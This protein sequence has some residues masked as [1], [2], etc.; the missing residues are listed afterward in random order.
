MNLTMLINRILFLVCFLL[1]ALSFASGI[2]YKAQHN[3]M[4]F[5]FKAY[6]SMGEKSIFTSY[7]NLHEALTYEQP[8]TNQCMVL[9]EQTG[10]LIAEFD[11]KTE[12]Y[13]DACIFVI[14]KTTSPISK[15]DDC[16]RKM[17]EIFYLHKGII[18]SVIK[19]GA[20]N[21]ADTLLQYTL[22]GIRDEL[23][24][25]KINSEIYFDNSHDFSKKEYKENFIAF[26]NDHSTFLKFRNESIEVTFSHCYE[27]IN[28]KNAE[29]FLNEIWT[30]LNEQEKELYNKTKV[31][32]ENMV[33]TTAVGDAIVNATTATAKLD[34]CF[35]TSQPMVKKYIHELNYDALALEIKKLETCYIEEAAKLQKAAN[36]YAA[37]IK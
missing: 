4:F 9:L 34:L 36:D 14:K 35:A 6:V 8:D 28:A 31:Y 27:R 7:Q 20:F 2:D 13:I 26:H 3:E 21:E 33:S 24:K 18:A 15:M 23:K 25:L 37:K 16:H 5:K 12:I 1:P 17:H 10:N 22:S 30:I 29:L 11:Q 19:R 32:Q